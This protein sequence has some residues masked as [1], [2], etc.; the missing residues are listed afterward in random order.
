[1]AW[2]RPIAASL[3]LVPAPFAARAESSANDLARQLSNPISSLISL[4][5][6]FNYDRGM[7]AA[8]NGH[9]TTINVQPVIP[10]SISE[11]WN[12][13]SRTIVPI[14]TQTD[15]IPGTSQSG[16]GDVVQSFFFSPKAP[17]A[18]G[19]I[20]GVGPVFLLPSGATGISA[21]QFGAG[22]TGVVLKQTGHWTYGAL[23]NHIWSVGSTTGGTRISS[24]YFQPFVSY[25]TPNAWTFALNTET[26]YDWLTDDASVPINFMVSKVTKFGRQPVSIGAGVR[27]YTDSM[28]GGPDGWGARVIL[29]FLYPK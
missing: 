3:L 14:I 24:T 23:A 12:L 11:D 21:D 20:W 25:N 7:G 27:Y 15:V 19:L 17:T 8:G 2:F 28:P 9:R 16:V 26:T 10:F 1:M 4:P 18:G 5:F 6:Q 13:I 29:T 22:I